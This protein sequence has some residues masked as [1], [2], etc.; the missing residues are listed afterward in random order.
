KMAG[1]RFADA[2][3]VAAVLEPGAVYSTR[4]NAGA[5]ARRPKV[6]GRTPASAG[7]EVAHAAT[8]AS[9]PDGA[10]AAASRDP[11]ARDARDAGDA[12]PRRRAPV[13]AVAF[14]TVAGLAA[15]GIWWA[16]HQGDRAVTPVQHS[17]SVK[18]ESTP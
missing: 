9:D 7:L 4:P 18:V 15:A 1:H 6:S 13:I 10:P 3:D 17:S 11:D 2:L 8:M 14:F 12:P 16:T 5:S